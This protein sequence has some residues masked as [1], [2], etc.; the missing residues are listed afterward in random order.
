MANK[1]KIKNPIKTSTTELPSLW[2]KG[3]FSQ[4]HSAGEVVEEFAKIGCH[5]GASAVSK[6]LLRAPFITRKGRR[7]GLRYIQTYPFEK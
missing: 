2:Q 3:F 7:N 4:W 6:A 1:Q 5:F